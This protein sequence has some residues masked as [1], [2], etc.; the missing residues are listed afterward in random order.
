MDRKEM[1][2]ARLYLLVLFLILVLLCYLG[3]LYDTHVV[4]HEDYVARSVRSIVREAST[5]SSRTMERTERA[6]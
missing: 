6:I 2:N 3:I 4:H 5:F 1:Q